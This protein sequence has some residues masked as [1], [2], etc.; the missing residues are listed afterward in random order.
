MRDDLGLEESPSK[1]TST[2]GKAVT[3][4]WM[5]GWR[6]WKGVIDVAYQHGA[7]GAKVDEGMVVLATN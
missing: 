1:V 5:L 4:T 3:Q 2:V 6:R 7:R